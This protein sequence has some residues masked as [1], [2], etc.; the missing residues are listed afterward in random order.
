M[1]KADVR[2][3]KVLTYMLWC[4]AICSTLNFVL[5]Y[6]ESHEISIKKEF[7]SDL[8]VFDFDKKSNEEFAGFKFDFEADIEGLFNWNTGIIFASLYCEYKG[9]ESELN[10]ITV[11]D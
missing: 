8:Q 1:Y 4:M 2:F 3:N 9:D 11:W 5:A 7:K 10:K 6:Y